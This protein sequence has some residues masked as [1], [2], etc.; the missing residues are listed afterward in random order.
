LKIS[1]EVNVD[2]SNKKKNAC[3]ALLERNLGTIIE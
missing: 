2:S 1:N 3:V